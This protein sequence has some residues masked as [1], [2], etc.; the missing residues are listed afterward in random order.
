MSKENGR[1]EKGNEIGKET[2]FKK[3]N[4]LSNKYKAEYIEKLLL[5][6]SE[7]KSDVHYERTYYKDGSIKSERPIILPPKFPTFELFAA[8]IGVT[9]NTL[10]N[11]CGEH[12]RFCEAY[13][14]AKTLQLGIAKVYAMSKMYDSNFAK[15]ILM[16]EHGMSEKSTSDTN[17]TFSVEYDTDEIDEESN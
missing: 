6:F 5:F 17:I 1:F 4:R 12:P 3:N 16:N 14:Y 2:R 10:R 11:W 8:S 13:E 7:P 9:S 15:F